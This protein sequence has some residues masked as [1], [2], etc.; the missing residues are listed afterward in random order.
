MLRNFYGEGPQDKGSCIHDHGKKSFFRCFSFCVCLCAGV[1]SG[2][3]G[4]QDRNGF[5]GWRAIRDIFE[6]W[7][8]F[9]F[10]LLFAFVGTL[11]FLDP[12]Q[13][14]FVRSVPSN[15]IIH[16]VNCFLA[17]DPGQRLNKREAFSEIDIN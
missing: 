3:S 4:V 7:S 15:Q 1:P 13:V 11:F 2:G 16:H 10:F 8:F 9:F 12:F 6:S 17:L 14:Y 5:V